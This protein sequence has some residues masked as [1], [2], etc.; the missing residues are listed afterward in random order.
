MK[1]A[2][3]S[4]HTPPDK[5]QLLLEAVYKGNL[6]EIKKLVKVG[7]DIKVR[8]HHGKTLLMC[9]ITAGH[10]SLLRPLVELG[11]DIN[12]QDAFGDTALIWA[13]ISERP[14]CVRSLLELGA[15]ITIANDEGKTALHYAEEENQ[16]EMMD[17]MTDHL[18]M[19]V[20]KQKQDR[21][22]AF[23][24]EHTILQQD[25]KPVKKFKIRG[26]HL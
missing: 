13:I 7:A 18:F 14:V 6:P 11:A 17:L 22:N 24:K 26:K 19:L 21:L 1:R 10:A 23:I 9:A 12:E 4:R 25:L 15:E 3:S 16:P 5:E 20:Q 2:F 8:N